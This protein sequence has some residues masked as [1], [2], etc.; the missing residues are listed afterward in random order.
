[1]YKSLKLVKKYIT[2]TVTIKAV[3]N[4]VEY[5]LCLI[6]TEYYWKHIN[7]LKIN[8]LAVSMLI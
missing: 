4:C 7:K 5:I 8:A 3:H 2:F 1:M 6:G